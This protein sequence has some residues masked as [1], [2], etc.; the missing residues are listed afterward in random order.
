MFLNNADQQ[1]FEFQHFPSSY[2][3][4]V[5]HRVA[6]HYNMQKMVQDNALDGQGSKI[7]VWKLPETKY[8]VV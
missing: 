5:A 3:Q 8:P 1:H 7:L 4:L 2:L 6:Q